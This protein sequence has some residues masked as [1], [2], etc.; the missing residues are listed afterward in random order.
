MYLDDGWYYV[1]RSEILLNRF[2]IE[3]TTENTYR[4]SRV[5]YCRN[6]LQGKTYQALIEAFREDGL[7]MS[8]CSQY[9]A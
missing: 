3:Q 2:L 5:Q 7:D 6:H 1:Y 8:D 4:I 9:D